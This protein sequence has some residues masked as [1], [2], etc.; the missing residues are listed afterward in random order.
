MDGWMDGWVHLLV[1]S[2][3]RPVDHT[4]PC[5]MLLLIVRGSVLALACC[6]GTIMFLLL[7]APRVVQLCLKLIYLMFNMISSII[8]D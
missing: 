3:D 8:S 5:N 2:L 4:I 1:C 7:R 6:Q